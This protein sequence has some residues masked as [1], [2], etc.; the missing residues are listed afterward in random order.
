MRHW[1]KTLLRRPGSLGFS[2]L[3]ASAGILLHKLNDHRRQGDKEDDTDD[4]KELSADHSGHK[5]VQRR[6]S[7]GFSHHPGVDELVFNKLYG[8]VNNE[9]AHGKNGIHQQH[10]EHADYAGNQRSDVGDNGADGGQHSHQAAVGNLENGKRKSHENAKDHSLAALSCQKVCKGLPEQPAELQQPSGVA[11]F[12]VGT[13]QCA[14]V[15]AET[16]RANGHINRDD[17]GKGCGHHNIY[18]GRYGTYRIDQHGVDAVGDP[19]KQ[20]LPVDALQPAHQPPH[21]G[22]LCAEIGGPAGDVCFDLYIETV[23]RLHQLR[24]QQCQRQHQHQHNTQQGDEEAQEMEYFIRGL[25]FGLAEQ[26]FQPF[27]QPGHRHI[28]K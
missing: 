1:G 28:D 24:D 21:V 26:A 9:T 2:C 5:G 23:K 15:V 3:Y 18:R 10:E 25:F 19:V 6:K 8:K 14:G 11:G 27:F 22:I 12:Q 7:H 13:D 16:L 4:A 17:Q 20:L